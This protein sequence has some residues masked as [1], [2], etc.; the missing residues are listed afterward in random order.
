M[1][2]HGIAAAL[3]TG[4]RAPKEVEQTGPGVA[5]QNH[6]REQQPQN[7]AAVA[8]AC[9]VSAT[10]DSDDAAACAHPW[11]PANAAPTELAR[12][13]GGTAR[14]SMFVT[15]GSTTPAPQ[16]QRQRLY[17]PNVNATRA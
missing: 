2:Q 4:R 10:V 9:A 17:F 15:D 11:K 5:L 3:P 14:D 8:D 12:R 13:A 7:G 6:R 16:A 1:R